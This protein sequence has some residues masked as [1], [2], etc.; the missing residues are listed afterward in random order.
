MRFKSRSRRRLWQIGWFAFA[1]LVGGHLLAT[2]IVRASSNEA[3]EALVQEA[4]AACQIA[5]DLDQSRVLWSN[6]AYEQQAAILITGKWKP[7]Q[8]KGKQG[9][10]LC[11]F[12]K[13]SAKVEI[14]EVDPTLFR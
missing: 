11:L 9:Y 12:D 1:A 4:S 5:S 14:Q 10:M 7:T 6:P 13:Q 3:W 8:M 2:E